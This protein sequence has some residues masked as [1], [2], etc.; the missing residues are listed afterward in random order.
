MTPLHLQ[1][2]RS[3]DKTTISDSNR[4]KALTP[5]LLSYIVLKQF[6]YTVISYTQSFPIHNSIIVI[7]CT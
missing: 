7:S 1:K 4:I 5:I 6:L 2:E 3:S